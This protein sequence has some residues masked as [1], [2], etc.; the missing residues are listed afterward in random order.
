M[1]TTKPTTTTTTKKP[2]ADELKFF[3]QYTQNR[4]AGKGQTAERDDYYNKL[5]TT[6]GLKA[7]NNDQAKFVNQYA[8]NQATGK[9]VTTARDSYMNTLTSTYGLKGYSNPAVQQSHD[10]LSGKIDFSKL[11]KTSDGFV[12]LPNGQYATPD[13]LMTLTQDQYDAFGLSKGKSTNLDEAY[14]IADKLKMEE[15]L[16]NMNDMYSPIIGQY[17]NYLSTLQGQHQNNLNAIDAQGNRTVQGVSDNNFLAAQENEQALADR[18]IGSSGVGDEF[19]TRN[20]MSANRNLQDAYMQTAEYKNQENAQFAEN[21]NQIKMALAELNPEAKAQAMY[22]EWLGTTGGTKGIREKKAAD[23]AAAQLEAEKQA[24]EMAKQQADIDAKY[25]AQTGTVWLNGKNTGVSTAGMKIDQA[26]MQ[27]EV[28]KIQNA[29]DKQLT[30]A[31]GYLYSG[32]KQVLYKG[33]PIKTIDYMKL[34]ETQRSNIVNEG[35]KQQAENRKGAELELKAQHWANQ[36]TNSMNLYNLKVADF[37]RKVA[38]DSADI[39]NMQANMTDKQNKTQMA[40]LKT[41]YDGLIK[42]IA[43]Q[44]DGKPTK[45][46]TDRLAELEAKM[47]SLFQSDMQQWGYSQAQGK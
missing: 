15:F 1:A 2:N 32:G 35:I 44:K 40:A 4:V 18:G 38:A 36:D 45:A 21:E 37:N 23:T 34:S 9:G 30:D 26:K 31:T 25:S 13:G 28:A 46:Q 41:Q 3:N 16:K 27:L 12:K 19:R 17:N 39:A 20:Q 29:K 10:A 8:A 33:K 43:K 24:L 47:Y 22:Q 11:E 7:I 42:L 14:G 6:Y 5:A